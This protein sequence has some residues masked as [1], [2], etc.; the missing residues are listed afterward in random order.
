M[1]ERNM[2]ADTY[3]YIHSDTGLPTRDETVNLKLNLLRSQG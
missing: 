1:N 3:L 2:T